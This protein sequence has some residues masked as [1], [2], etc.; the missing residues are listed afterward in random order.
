MKTEYDFT[1]SERG[2]FYSANADFSFPVHL[3]PDVDDFMSK[4]ADERKI[5]VEA[6]VNEWLRASIKIIQSISADQVGKP[7]TPRAAGTPPLAQ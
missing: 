4:L 2:K 3:E 6:L 5:A 1:K 7:T